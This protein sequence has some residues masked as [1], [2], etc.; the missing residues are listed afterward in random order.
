MDYPRQRSQT[1]HSPPEGRRSEPEGSSA[2]TG[3]AEA[4]ATGERER[5]DSPRRAKQAHHRQSAPSRRGNKPPGENRPRHPTSDKQNNRNKSGGQMGTQRD[6]RT[7]AKRGRPRKN[8]LTSSPVFSQSVNHNLPATKCSCKA[9]KGHDGPTQETRRSHTRDSTVS[10]ARRSSHKQ[11][12]RLSINH[13][14]TSCN[15]VPL[16]SNQGTR[17]S[18]TRDTT[19]SHKKQNV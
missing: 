16:Q 7:N 1:L 12:S 18:H 14:Q 8:R 19:V 5:Q 2:Q 10:H 4:G 15:R 17:R 9:N 13:S 6:H 3:R 11:S